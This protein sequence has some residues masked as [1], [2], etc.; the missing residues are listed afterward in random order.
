MEKLAISVVEA[1]KLI[2]VSKSTMYALIEQ[3][4][5]PAVHVG[6]KRIIIPV[7]ALQEWLSQRTQGGHTGEWIKPST[8]RGMSMTD[9]AC[10]NTFKSTADR[11]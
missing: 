9:S 3:K 7:K 5:I 4:Q 6:G 2:S 8:E 10:T 11:R 1:A